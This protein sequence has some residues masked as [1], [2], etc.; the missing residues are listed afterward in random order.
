MLK[1]ILGLLFVGL[2]FTGC[3]SKHDA[4]KALNAEGMTNIEVT[5]YNWF[6]C[7]KDDFYHTGFKATNALGKPVEGTVCSGLLFKGSTIRY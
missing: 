3:T 4:E 2:V 5:G 6:A 7:S 1:S